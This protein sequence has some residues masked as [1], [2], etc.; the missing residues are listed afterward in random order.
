MRMRMSG[1]LTGPSFP[2]V[3]AVANSLI[4]VPGLVE[5]G[6][7]PSRDLRQDPGLASTLRRHIRD[8]AHA[9]AYPPHRVYLGAL[10]AT[11]LRALPQPW[12]A[13][14]VPEA[15]LADG[16]R[17]VSEVEFFGW[18]KIL[19]RAG[20]IL[21]GPEFAERARTALQASPLATSED[22]AALEC[23]STRAEIEAV[24]A[25]G[26]GIP[27]R[28]GGTI[29]GAC[30]RAHDQDPSLEAAVLLENLCCK[31]S[32]ALAL[33]SLV[34]AVGRTTAG[35][36]ECVLGGSEEAVGDRYQRGGGNLGKAIAEVAW[37][38]A[39][40]GVD[41]KAFCASTVHAL[42][43]AAAL[44]QAKVFRR[45]A[46]VAGGSLA[47]LGM[48]YRGHLARGMPVLEDVLAGVA[49]LVGPAAPGRPVIRLDCVGWHPV[50]AGS[51]QQ[52]ILSALSVGPLERVG[53]GLCDV[54]RFATE[55][56]NP[57]ITVPAGSGDVA[58]G[59]YRMLAAIAA[60]R[61]EIGRGD[62]DAFIQAHGLPGFAPTQG[63]IAS[64]I[65]Y[66]REAC[67]QLGAG[68]LSRVLLMAKGSLFL[69]RMTQMADGCSVLLEAPGVTTGR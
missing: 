12:Y 37:L 29:V 1:I 35:E 68:Q 15:P 50:G 69:G 46:V 17:L 51:A 11:A 26:E 9:A 25:R 34:Q 44:V 64:A 63:H 23:I 6:S 4:H 67:V 18:L 10:D 62:L 36:I 57:E 41:V 22:L 61:G 8:Y 45:V 38:R 19:D 54:D 31:A 30:L 5:H 7:K 42:I 49:F 16:A 21:L 66:L 55:L 43:I 40:G 32:G 33:R 28:H 52:E 65:C 47:K 27:L 58:A 39:A 60:L 53:L 59:N 56:H 13:A 2:V 14:P 3:E 24:L 48:K 20:L